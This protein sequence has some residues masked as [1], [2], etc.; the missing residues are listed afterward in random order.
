MFR[1]YHKSNNI[2]T[3]IQQKRDIVVYI[4]NKNKMQAKICKNLKLQLF[5]I[6]TLN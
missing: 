2:K 4:N 3:K 5:E 1:V 6:I